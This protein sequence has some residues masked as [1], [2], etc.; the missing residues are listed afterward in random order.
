[1]RLRLSVISTHTLR[2]EGDAVILVFVRVIHIFQPTPSA[3]RVTVIADQYELDDDIS[4]HTL[5]KEGDL[6]DGIQVI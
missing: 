2:K 6:R 1:M 3:R 5:R 4:T